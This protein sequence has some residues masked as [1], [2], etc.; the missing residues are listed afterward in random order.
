M[1]VG[2][3]HS[4]FRI[5]WKI[6]IKFG[7]EPSDWTLHP[8]LY[9]LQRR[10]LY[11][12]WHACSSHLRN[13]LK[14][15]AMY[16]VKMCCG[17]SWSKP[18]PPA[19]SSHPFGHPPPPLPSEFARKRR[20][21]RVMEKVHRPTKVSHP[22]NVAHRDGEVVKKKR[23]HDMM[24]VM[25]FWLHPRV[26]FLLHRLMVRRIISSPNQQHQWCRRISILN[27]LLYYKV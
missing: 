21:E 18:P 7:D 27:R 15:Y 13:M 20:L 23:A 12:P 26:Q 8:L 9:T 25:R 10:S 1:D 4:I 3:T 17:L 2:A 24:V 16:M 14:S 22:P 5:W 11:L 6:P 19:P